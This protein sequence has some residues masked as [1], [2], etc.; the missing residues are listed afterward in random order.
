VNRPLTIFVPHCSDLFTDHIA[1]GDGL[2]AHGFLSR[3]AR[4]GHRLHIVAQQVDLREPL[5]PNVTIYSAP[6]LRSGGFLWRLRYMHHVRQLFWQLRRNTQFDLIHQ[7]NPVFTGLSLSLAGSGVPL[8]LGTYV[9]HWPPDPNASLLARSANRITHSFRD[10]ISAFQ[11]WRADTLVLTTP[12]AANRLPILSTR[13]EKISFLPHGVDTALFSP[14]LEREERPE[15]QA[16]TILFFANVVKRKGIF[17][18]I[19]AFAHVSKQFPSA[20]LLIAGDGPALAEAKLRACALP[21]AQQIEFSGQRLRAD[22]P[23]VLRNC[24]IYCLPSFGEPYA[25]TLIEAMSC[26][27]PVVT[28]HS[29]GSPHLVPPHGGI[30]LP[31]GDVPALSRALLELLADPLR[32]SDMGRHNRQFVL[33]NMSW[34]SIIHQLE[35]IYEKTLRRFAA[36]YGSD[37]RANF[38]LSPRPDTQE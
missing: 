26:G 29:G 38:V 25:T 14:A 6:A 18:L 8:V 35:A 28:T 12:A 36:R 10:A 32:C 1:H 24:T 27:K 15:N 2:I 11:Q 9:P 5:P 37:R 23:A 17:T 13:H 34:D 20:R 22:A 3:L 31:P 21:C 7:L 30:L 16:P 4:A 33:A 19:D